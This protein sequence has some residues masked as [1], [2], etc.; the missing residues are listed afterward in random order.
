MDRGSTGDTKIVSPGSTGKLENSRQ[1]PGTSLSGRRYTYCACI[2]RDMTGVFARFVFT[3][4]RAREK[5]S[6]SS[7][8]HVEYPPDIIN[9]DRS[10]RLD[11]RSSLIS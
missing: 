2:D 3:E 5:N 10:E 9:A 8:G 7:S 4:K 11:S 6:K 1:A